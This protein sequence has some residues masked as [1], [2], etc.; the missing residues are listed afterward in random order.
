MKTKFL[1]SVKW[2]LLKLNE[3]DK[4]MFYA[5]FLHFKKISFSYTN[6]LITAH[7]VSVLFGLLLQLRVVICAYSGRGVYFLIY[8]ILDK[9]ILRNLA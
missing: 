7:F 5:L 9:K 2:M 1:T 6:L 3:K 8:S 4:W